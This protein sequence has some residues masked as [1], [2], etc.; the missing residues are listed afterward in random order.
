MARKLTIRRVG[1]LFPAACLVALVLLAT[2]FIWLSTAGLPGWAL[3]RIEAAAAAEGIHLDVKQLKLSPANG[4]AVRAR[5]VTLYAT[6]KKEQKLASVQRATLGIS[7]TALVRGKVQPTMAEFRALD[8]DLP[9]D[10]DQPLTLRD[11]TASARISQGEYVRLTSARAELQGIPVTVRGG[12]R[13]PEAGAEDDEPGAP[14]DIPA[15]LEPYKAE[16]GYARRALASQEWTAETRPSVELSV[17]ATRNTQLGA[18]IR[19]PQY[20]E[21]QFHFRNALIDVAYQNNTLLINSVRFRTVE[22][23]SEVK[24]QG[25]Y[26]IPARHLSFSLESTAA[27]ARMAEALTIPGVDMEAIDAWLH[28]FR[29]P[30]AAPPHINLSGDVN[31]EEDFTLKA[32]SVTGQL[33]L[34]DFT[35]GQTAVN[36]LEL[37]L[38]Y[39]D[40]SFNI[41]RLHLD[42]PGGTLLASASASSAD[43]KGK[44]KIDA[45]MDI[46]Q[47]LGLVSE[48]TDEP[49]ALPEGLALDGRVKLALGAQLDMPKFVAGASELGQFIP[50]VHRAELALGVGKAAYEGYEAVNP[51]LSLNFDHVHHGEDGSTARG[52]AQAQLQFSAA[53]LTLPQGEGGEPVT[54]E[55]AKVALELGELLFSIGDEPTPPTLASLTGKLALGSLAIPGFEAK[56]LELDIA[57]AEGIRPLADDWRHLLAEAALKLRA[58]SLS[59]QDTLLGSLDSALSLSPQGDIDLDL[60]L[61]REGHRIT[62]DLHPQ[63]TEEGL[64]VL[65][66]IDLELPAAGFA[67][68]LG[69]AGVNITQIQLPNTLTLKGD[70]TY[71]TKAKA[72][73][74]GQAALD[75]PHIVRTPGARNPAFAGN[76]QPLALHVDATAKGR[77]DG[78]ADITGKLALTHKGDADHEA[79]DRHLLLDFTVDTVGKAHL[80]GTNTID[81]GEVDQLIDL[82]S[83]HEIM[84]DFQTDAKT[85]LHLAINAVDLDFTDGLTV[86][87]DCDI[88]MSDFGY[89][90]NAL[91][92]ELG[93]DG[94]PTGREP[95]RKDFGKNPFRRIEKMSAHV[96]V[97]YKEDAEE[98]PLET[99]ITI[100]KVDLT[101]DNR[102]WIARHG[103]KGGE[104]Q[105]NLQ[106]D[107]VVIDIERGFVELAGVKGRVYPAYSLGAFYDELPTFLEDFILPEPARIESDHCLFP[108]YSECKRDMSGCIRIMAPKADFRFLGT[109]F[110]FTTLSGF[111]W[112]TEGSVLLDKLN[113]G[114]WDGGI[115][116]AV[117]ID[118]SGRHTGFDGYAELAN[119][120]LKPLAASYGSEQ[121]PALCN[122]SIRFR[123]PSSDLKALEAYGE[124][125]I[126]DGDLM[127]LSIFR[128]VG[129]LISDLPGNL[130]ELEKKAFSSKGTDPSWIDRQIT[131]AFRSTGRA[132]SIVGEQVG[133][134]TDNIPFANHFLRYDLQEVHS[135]FT[136]GGGKLR[137]QGMKALGFNLN[138]GIDLTLDLDE[139]TLQ[140]DLWPK[141]SSVP[142]VILS[143]LTF[144]SDFMIDIQVFGP[145]DDIDWKF[146]L[147]RRKGDDGECLSADPAEHGMQPR[148]E[149]KA[150]Q[151]QKTPSKGKAKKS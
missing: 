108:I 52:F 114:C 146:G 125:H 76:E 35:F 43:G 128:P 48:F 68:L 116:A 104:K 18:V 55:G 131:K 148:A 113:A 8:I 28:R 5:G 33:G 132:F 47:L 138:V 1:G 129:D 102:Q 127:N 17:E 124:A 119:V 145:I 14:L 149:K 100:T 87:A 151:K 41:D 56:G 103:F 71:D 13:L 110:P 99:V 46:P 38:F 111:I 23:D 73:V 42:F 70:V 62:L 29:H 144:L 130:A 22:P 49:V 50:T 6:E 139:L 32:I 60:A 117:N 53:S 89:Q 9:T 57:K 135:R 134:V 81:V 80:S 112:L 15:L 141:I 97:F 120:N 31:F 77:A 82:A 36:A 109:T 2:T 65:D 30:D 69:L 24:L 74:S 58:A 85:D 133:H 98:K 34:K 11:A 16:L 59:T 86:T 107:K 143:P 64:L 39:R 19:I 66:H 27:L 95:L 75:I 115:N 37:S 92:P 25:G 51:L 142:T 54:M 12:F 140:G 40:G 126:V 105:S 96:D 7:L 78:N 44:A 61:E 88:R 91:E 20:D 21:E 67:P 147:N 4:L 26:D 122:A 101:Y 106:G 137:T 136:I 3:R 118:Y 10:G 121:N 150:Q 63:L 93:A 83:A 90:M 123:T 94:K 45:D 72:L 79:D 84:R